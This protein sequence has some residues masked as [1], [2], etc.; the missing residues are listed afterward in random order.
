MRVVRRTLTWSLRSQCL[1]LCKLGETQTA[2]LNLLTRRSIPYQ[3]LDKRPWVSAVSWVLACG[4]HP[5]SLKCSLLVFLKQLD[6]NMSSCFVT[7]GVMF[8]SFC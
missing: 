7:D 3:R 5:S 6:T 2:N 4:L 1:G 8:C